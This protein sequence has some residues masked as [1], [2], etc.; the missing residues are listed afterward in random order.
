MEIDSKFESN[1]AYRQK[2]EEQQA[3][4]EWQLLK[5]S[6][7][8]E[9]LSKDGL[10]KS[11]F[12]SFKLKRPDSKFSR[13]TNPPMSRSLNLKMDNPLKQHHFLSKTPLHSKHYSNTQALHFKNRTLTEKDLQNS[14]DSLTSK[15]PPP[16]LRPL[17]GRQAS[18]S[19]VSGR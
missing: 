19:K 7:A 1:V 9:A 4:L 2:T 18:L 14:S 17:S 12:L 13:F 11:V 3:M 15:S 16:L 5:L 10:P 6:E 8:E